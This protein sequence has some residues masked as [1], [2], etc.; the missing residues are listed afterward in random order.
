[1]RP[2][3]V[4]EAPARTT[5]PGWPA[6][7]GRQRSA[8]VLWQLGFRVSRAPGRPGN[9]DAM[10]LLDRYPGES[11]PENAARRQATRLLMRGL[12]GR[13]AVVLVGR[14]VAAAFDAED[15]PWLEWFDLFGRRAAV[16]PH[17]SGLNR[18]WNE[19]R[20]YEAAR[21]FAGKLLGL[22]AR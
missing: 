22:G 4:G 20:N 15:R 5:S 14:R 3:L 17:P 18:W 12:D 7:Y 6:F 16:M 13:K 9:T 1:M 8:R 2:L 10:N 21:V 11:W 19:V